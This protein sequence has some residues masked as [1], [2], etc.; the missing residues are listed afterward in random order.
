MCPAYGKERNVAVRLDK[1]EAARSNWHYRDQG[2]G[3]SQPPEFIDSERVRAPKSLA[4]EID[5]RDMREEE[6]V[7]NLDSS[8]IRALNLFRGSHVFTFASPHVIIVNLANG[9]VVFRRNVS[10]KTKIQKISILSV[11]SR[12]LDTKSSRH[13][14]QRSFN[15][16]NFDEDPHGIN[17]YAFLKHM[18]VFPIFENAIAFFNSA[19]NPVRRRKFRKAHM[20][21]EPL[22]S[23]PIVNQY[24]LKIDQRIR[25]LKTIH[26]EYVQVLLSPVSG[27]RHSKTRGRWKGAHQID[28]DEKPMFLPFGELH[29]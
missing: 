15:Q 14:I 26:G 8:R 29:S 6:N 19:G 4:S 3:Q 16:V 5:R 11:T 23:M 7:E 17:F 9:N 10:L 22:G 1:S 25:W 13:S 20:V 18:R 28:T 12:Y 2:E 24:K 27:R 21:L